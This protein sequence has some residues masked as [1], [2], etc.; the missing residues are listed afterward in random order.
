MLNLA[1]ETVTLLI[2]DELDD[3]DVAIS[4]IVVYLS[5][6]RVEAIV[7]TDLD[8]LGANN[9]DSL[10]V[11]YIFN[12]GKAVDKD[13]NILKYIE[14]AQYNKLDSIEK[15]KYWSIN[16]VSCGLIPYKVNIEDID[17]VKKYLIRS[18]QNHKSLRLGH[19]ELVVV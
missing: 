14:W 5:G 16:D 6:C 9:N 3:K 13:G 8:D 17:N 11:Y 1:D 18:I 4:N 7:S 10:R 2:P 12:K 15:V 19:L